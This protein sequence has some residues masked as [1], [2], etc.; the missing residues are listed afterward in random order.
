MELQKSWTGIVFF[1]ACLVREI[2]GDSL[3]GQKHTAT[4]KESIAKCVAVAACGVI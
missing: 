4:A 2:V 1:N 3:G